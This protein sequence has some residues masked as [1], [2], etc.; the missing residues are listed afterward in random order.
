[1][2][3]AR[4]PTGGR[5]STQKS[6]DPLPRVLSFASAVT[7]RRASAIASAA[8]ASRRSCRYRNAAAS[9]SEWPAQ[10]E[11]LRL[12]GGPSCE[13]LVCSDQRASTATR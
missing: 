7:G 2:K 12:A 10:Q 13:G 4:L 3:F 1:M 11:E 6:K 5:A 9:L 8:G